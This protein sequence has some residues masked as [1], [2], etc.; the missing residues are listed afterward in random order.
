MIRVKGR[1]R[2]SGSRSGGGSIMKVILMLRGQ[3]LDYNTPWCV[4]AL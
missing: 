2:G 1:G 4:C 3:A